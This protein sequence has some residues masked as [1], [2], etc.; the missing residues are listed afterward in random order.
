MAVLHRDLNRRSLS[1]LGYYPHEVPERDWSTFP[2]RGG[3]VVGTDEAIRSSGVIE[4]G[5]NHGMRN[6]EGLGM[7]T[8]DGLGV[9]HGERLGMKNGEGL[10]VRSGDGFGMKN[11]EGSSSVNFHPHSFH[12]TAF[13]DGTYP[14]D[15]LQF[16]FIDTSSAFLPT[17]LPPSSLALSDL[18]SRELV[19]EKEAMYRQYSSANTNSN[20]AS[21]SPPEQDNHGNNNNEATMLS[22]V[23]GS[24]DSSFHNNDGDGGINEKSFFSQK[25]VQ[26]NVDL[27]DKPP[28]PKPRPHSADPMPVNQKKNVA[29]GADQR[30]KYSGNYSTNQQFPGRFSPR[31][32]GQ[33]Q[34]GQEAAGHWTEL[35]S[36]KRESRSVPSSPATVQSNASADHQQQ[37]RASPHIFLLQE[38]ARKLEKEV[39]RDGDTPEEKTRSRHR[40]RSWSSRSSRDSGGDHHHREADSG[41]QGKLSSVC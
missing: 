22:V 30:E 38:A 27:T 28:K 11:G 4:N 34:R 25:P 31:G 8:G 16:A 36:Q 9:R 23:A 18:K 17:E 5:L 6:G 20:N 1:S 21:D 39:E 10:R 14:S 24:R 12:N 15:S 13:N 32:Q 26:T 41:K 29:G 7:K 33:S 3:V 37:H 19:R 40:H 35:L 2:S